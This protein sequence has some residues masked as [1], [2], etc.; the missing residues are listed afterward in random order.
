MKIKT[1]SLRHEVHFV[2]SPE[3]FDFEKN[4]FI[5]SDG[6]V[7]GYHRPEL[8]NLILLGSEDPACDPQN[9]IADP[10]H[11]DTDV[12]PEQWKAQVYRL[13]KR[14]RSLPIPDRP[15]GIVD[16]YDVTDDWIPIYDKSD[17]GGFYLAIGTSG[18]QYKNGPV[19]GRLMTEIIEACE[20]GH[21]HDRD[22]VQLQFKYIDFRLDT[23][24]F[25][26]LREVIEDSTSFGPGV[27]ESFDRIGSFS[28]G[29]RSPD[30]VF[31]YTPSGKRSRTKSTP[32]STAFRLTSTIS[33]FFNDS[34]MT[35]LRVSIPTAPAA[36]A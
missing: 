19:V 6:D 29:S 13:A 20:S 28:A 26:R 31:G 32:A 12:T 17:L 9:W 5:S 35:F 15:K 11:F 3:G 10:D 27:G 1:R 34:G 4:G 7:G 25:S 18:N 21:D 14:I 2:P 8:G 36:A 16:L 22:P 23:G 33:F 24:V 30:A